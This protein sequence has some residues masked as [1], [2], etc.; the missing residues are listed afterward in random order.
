M[1]K[2]DKTSEVEIEQ[3]LDVETLKQALVEEKE[4]SEKYLTNWQRSQADFENYK[5]RVEREK[6]EI[7]DSANN[8]LIS[9]LSTVV[10]DVERAFASLP[11]PLTESDWIEGIKLIY[12]KFKA[13]LEAQG[14]TEIKAKGEPFDPH[15][16]EAVMR[17]EGEEGMVIEEIQKGYKLK[18]KVIRPS[19]VV[20]GQ[21]KEDKEAGQEGQK[22]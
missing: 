13:V 15:L 6:E 5:K 2:N 11:V 10:D 16:H 19:L 21:G 14:L 8:T 12:K 4:K 20:V 3:V 1:T 18:N 17:R 22:E 7:V 9:N